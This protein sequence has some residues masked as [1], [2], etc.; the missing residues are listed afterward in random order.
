MELAGTS[1]WNETIGGA[2]GAITGRGPPSRTVL[3]CSRRR[4]PFGGS[5]R[6]H[7]GSSKRPP[8]SSTA[9]DGQPCAAPALLL[10]SNMTPPSPS[11]PLILHISWRSLEPARLQSTVQINRCSQ[12]RPRGALFAEHALA[13]R[14]VIAAI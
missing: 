1:Y 6:S 13:E 5:G 9:Q 2:A 11:M 12:R 7:R 8:K 3:S 4:S 10:S 14:L